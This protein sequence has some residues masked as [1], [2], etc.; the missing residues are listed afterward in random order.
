MC[1][2]PCAS[3]C[4]CHKGAHPPRILPTR[5]DTRAAAPQH[6][7][8]DR[9]TDR[10]DNVCDTHTLSTELTCTRRVGVPIVSYRIPHV[11]IFISSHLIASFHLPT[12]RPLAPRLGTYLSPSPALATSR[13]QTHCHIISRTMNSSY[14]H[15]CH[16]TSDA[17]HAP[18]KSPCMRSM[19]NQKQLLPPSLARATPRNLY[20]YPLWF[21]PSYLPL[22]PLHAWPDQL[23]SHMSQLDCPPSAPGPISTSYCLLPARRACVGL[24]KAGRLCSFKAPRNIPTYSPSQ[25]FAAL[26]IFSQTAKHESFVENAGTCNRLCKTTSNGHLQHLSRH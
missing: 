9:Q 24:G 23:H 8:T 15:G 2:C 14:C 1:V 17:A 6:R 10:Q 18:T 3:S 4:W 20:L 13:R 22:P 7:S 11:N 5:H 21:A 19:L 25:T 12:D 16:Y 26:V